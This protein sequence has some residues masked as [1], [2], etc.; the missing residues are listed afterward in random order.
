MKGVL[1]MGTKVHAKQL[2]PITQLYTD[3]YEELQALIYND[4]E[5]LLEVDIEYQFDVDGNVVKEVIQDTSVPPVVIKTTEYVY[6]VD[7]N[8]TTETVAK[9][10]KI[11]Q[12]YY[13]YD[14]NGNVTGVSIRKI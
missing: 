6:D 12:K 5:N 2:S 3:L 14:V 8:V 9:G 7:G 10:G 4:S 1:N 11:L 13:S